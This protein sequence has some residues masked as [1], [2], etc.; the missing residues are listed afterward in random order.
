MFLANGNSSLFFWTLNLIK[1][2]HHLNHSADSLKVSGLPVP[3]ICVVP[4][5]D[6]SKRQH[7]VF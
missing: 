2:A 7:R 6:L 5:S 4:V 3:F 1:S